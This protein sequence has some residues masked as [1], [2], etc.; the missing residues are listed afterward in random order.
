MKSRNLRSYLLKVVLMLQIL[1][2]FQF[3]PSTESRAVGTPSSYKKS[4]LFGTKDSWQEVQLDVQES[5]HSDHSPGGKLT[6]EDA[7]NRALKANRGLADAFDQ[8]E[9][10]RLT[11]VSAEAEFELKIFPGAEVG[12][13]GASGEDSDDTIG[14]GI[15]LQ[16]RFAV[17][18]DLSVRPNVQKTGDIYQT[19]IDTS[20]T[21]PLLRGF[22]REFNLSG[23]YGAEF[24]ARS[25]RRSL[26]LT[27]VSTV[28][29]M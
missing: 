15:S 3:V 5:L 25:A 19:S 1:L 24:G 23:L 7:I 11:I 18:T 17:G 4:I 14:V 27:Q 9:G 2:F 20:L 28:L 10:A 16:K 26:Y 22:G 8:V 29:A 12:I 21:Q 6:L 13:T